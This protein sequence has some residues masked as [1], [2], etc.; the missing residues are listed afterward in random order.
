[1]PSN[2]KELII[3]NIYEM[4][5][6][7]WQSTKSSKQSVTESVVLRS[8]ANKLR[9]RERGKYKAKMRWTVRPSV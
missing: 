4:Y 9:K 6:S 3:K 2:I 8:P 7:D 1:M 5:T